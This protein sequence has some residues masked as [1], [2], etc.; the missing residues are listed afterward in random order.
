MN[1]EICILAGGLSTRL[2]KDKARLRFG[3]R[4]MLSIIR[5][6]AAKLKYPVRIIRR[7]LV[8]RCGPLGGIFTALKT[9]RA[10]TVLFLACDMPLITNK[11]LK[12]LVTASGAKMQ[13]VIV[14]QDNQLGFPFILPRTVLA[15][16]ESQVAREQF[17]IHALAVKVKARK[18]RVPTRSHELF[19][20]N[21]VEDAQ[22]AAE[23]LADRD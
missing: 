22:R 6:E 17:S 14:A 4:T 18:L 8:P 1:L 7:D 9:T 20:V 15:D 16:V 23:L 10:E 2:G 3:R 13:P 21:T 12:R 11:L 5:S 19:N